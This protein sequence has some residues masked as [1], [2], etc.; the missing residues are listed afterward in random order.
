MI[1]VGT[2]LFTAISK[3][4]DPDHLY[5]WSFSRSHHLWWA[6]RQ[7]RLLYM[8]LCYLYSQSVLVTSSVSVSQ[9]WAAVCPH[10][11][12][13]AGG[14]TR[15][16]CCP[17]ANIHRL[18]CFK[19][20]EWDGSVWDHPQQCLSEYVTYRVSFYPG[21]VPHCGLTVRVCLPICPQR[22]NGFQPRRGH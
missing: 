1:S 2:G 21:P 16:Q 22:S 4:D 13:P 5:G 7:V 6:V 18:L 3:A 10:L 8:Y 9:V 19:I 17:L 20:P 14:C 11:V 15:Q 12:I